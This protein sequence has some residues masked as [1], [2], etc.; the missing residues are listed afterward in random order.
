MKGRRS[1][2][3]AL[4]HCRRLYNTCCKAIRHGD[5][6]AYYRYCTIRYR[7]VSRRANHELQFVRRHYASAAVLE[8]EYRE[9][10]YGRIK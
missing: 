1:K 6:L 9:T 8:R 5:A 2:R 4:W 10:A 3:W 7:W